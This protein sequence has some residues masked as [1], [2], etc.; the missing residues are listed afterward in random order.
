VTTPI[1]RRKTRRRETDTVQTFGELVPTGEA[2]THA[3]EPEADPAAAL[4]AQIIGGPP[5]RGLKGGA[6]TLKA[7]R[8]VYLETEYSGSADRRPKPG[9]VT[10]TEA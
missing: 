3:P 4:N 1:D 5:R 9:R 2:R 7:A 8:S 10:K 6:E